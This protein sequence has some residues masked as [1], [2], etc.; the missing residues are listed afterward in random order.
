M[1]PGV[2][3]QI[4]FSKSR[5]RD[6]YFN[7][8]LKTSV[9]TLEETLPKAPKEVA[10]VVA[11]VKKSSSEECR[12][13]PMKITKP[14]LNESKV[15]KAKKVVEKL[16]VEKRALIIASIV[17][18]KKLLT[19]KVEDPKK[20]GE[21]PEPMEIDEII[22]NVFINLIFYGFSRSGQP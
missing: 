7:S 13:A 15:V 21:E 20:R 5:Q 9:W 3:W 10:V 18:D 12:R 4:C 16:G 8:K 6:Y 22:E 2:D 14:K 11:K 1:E 17:K 19:K